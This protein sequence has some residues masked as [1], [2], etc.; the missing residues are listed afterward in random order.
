MRA[1]FQEISGLVRSLVLYIRASKL[2]IQALRGVS[3]VLNH[4]LRLKAEVT[5]IS[6][7]SKMAITPIF[8]LL[9]SCNTKTTGM[10]KYSRK[11]SNSELS[12]P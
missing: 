5:H 12:T 2:A 9:G 6:P 10:G 3:S 7:V 1:K 11:R 4:Q 8:L